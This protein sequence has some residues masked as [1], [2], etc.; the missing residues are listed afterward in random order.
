MNYIYTV[1]VLKREGKETENG[2]EI[3]LIEEKK[4]RK[5]RRNVL[6]NFFCFIFIVCMLLPSFS[7]GRRFFR[8]MFFNLFIHNEICIPVQGNQY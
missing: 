6:R 5:G 3:K 1:Q 7:V 8:I 4:R 2:K